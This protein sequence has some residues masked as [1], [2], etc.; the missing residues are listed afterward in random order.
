MPTNTFPRLLG[1]ASSPSDL[2]WLDSICGQGDTW[3]ARSL[4]DTGSTE[5]PSA[6]EHHC[7]W[8]PNPQAQRHQNREVRPAMAPNRGCGAPSRGDAGTASFVGGRVTGPSRVTE[9]AADARAIFGGTT[10]GEMSIRDGHRRALCIRCGRPVSVADTLQ[11]QPCVPAGRWPPGATSVL[12]A[13]LYSRTLLAAPD[14][15]HTRAALMARQGVD[16]AA[17]TRPHAG[18][19]VEP[20]C[21]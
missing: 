3:H 5:P 13:G 17:P 8:T 15:A 4:V 16:P 20:A 2:G 18:G 12:R 6:S 9:H 1:Q 10:K 14:W 7:R 21:S 19:A 11:R